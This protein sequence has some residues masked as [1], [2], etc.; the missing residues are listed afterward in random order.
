MYNKITVRYLILQ[1]LKEH[2]LMK[3]SKIG[4]ALIT[5]CLTVACLLPTVSVMT[6]AQKTTF[7]SSYT[8]WVNYSGWY[9]QA[10]NSTESSI[11]GKDSYTGT[12]CY[13]LI[14]WV[15]SSDYTTR[16]GAHYKTQ[17]NGG[18]ATER[19]DYEYWALGTAYARYEFPTFTLV[20][21][22]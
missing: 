16:Y 22:A 20:E 12:C 13:R 7:V 9:K 3:K 14:C 4:I 11:T 18:S 1:N 8:G 2:I 17:W 19:S 15:G 5:S 10:C 21:N 6:D